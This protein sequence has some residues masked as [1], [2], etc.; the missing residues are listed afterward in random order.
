MLIC[1]HHLAFNYGDSRILENV[2]IDVE[3]G[4]Y[5]V[6]AGANG[7][8]KSTLIKGLVGLK[9]PQEGVIHYSFEHKSNGLGYMPQQHVFQKDFPASVEEIARTGLPRDKGFSPFFSKAEKREVLRILNLL[10]I[11]DLARKSFSTL[12]GG[13]Q[14]RVLLAR[15]LLASRELLIL[16]E[17]TAGLDPLVTAE[18][19]Q[20]L[21]TL[22]AKGTALVMVSHDLKLALKDA[23]K[24]L[25]LQEGI[26]QLY[27]KNDFL[28]SEIGKKVVQK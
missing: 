9:K 16:D 1:A 13:Q 2:N 6:I 10:G 14:Q 26:A 17:P 23:N 25:Y 12:S 5:L 21:G 24:V 3:K 19:Y 18:F 7:A 4:D 15:A 22:N 28:Q 20:I 11:G 27:S 8:G